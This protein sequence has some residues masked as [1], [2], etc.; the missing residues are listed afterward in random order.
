MC[1]QIGRLYACF[2]SLLP[3]YSSPYRSPKDTKHFVNGPHMRSA[4]FK[5]RLL[6]MLLFINLCVLTLGLSSQY[7][8]GEVGTRLNKFTEG[9][10]TRLEIANRLRESVDTRALALRNRALLVDPAQRADAMASYAQA[11]A[12]ASKALSDLQTA[13]SKAALPRQVIEKINRIADVEHRYGSIAQRIAD[14]FQDGQE[15]EALHLMQTAC[16]PT[17]AELS[18]AIHDYM[19]LT[20]QRT[21]AYVQETGDIAAW[22]RDAMLTTAVLAL[23]LSS[24][25]GYLLWLNVRKTMGCQ[26]EELKAQLE[27]MATGDLSSSATAQDVER[28]SILEALLRTQGQVRK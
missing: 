4:T 27:S 2:F 25:M 5:S 8:L 13:A 3:T 18:A 23:C 20:E 14:R 24:G 1:L 12:A 22:Q 7:F 15:E 19:A 16:T 17:L 26:P 10:Y 28:G 11:H 9:I 6:G 21:S